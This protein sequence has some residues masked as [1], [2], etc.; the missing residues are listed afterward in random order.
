V[1]N[2][3]GPAEGSGA[4]MTQ[5]IGRWASLNG[6]SEVSDLKYGMDFRKPEYRREVFLRFYEFHLRYRSHPGGVYFLLPFLAE[7]HRWNLEQRLWF[8]YING[9]TQNPITSYLIFREFGD[10]ARLDETALRRWFERNYDL[11]AF[12]TD[13]R[14][15]KKSFLECVA[16]YRQLLAG[17]TQAEFFAAVAPGATEHARFRALWNYANKNYVY[18]GRLSVF[19]YTEYLRISGLSIDCDSLFLDDISG[20]KSHRNG[21]CKVLGRDDLDWHASNPGFDGT[22]DATM[23][24]WLTSEGAQLLAEAKARVAGKDYERDAGYFTLESALCTYKSWHRPNRRYPNCYNDMLVE[25]IRLAEK[26]WGKLPLFW[27]ARR[28][29]LPAALRLED[30][31]ADCGLKPKKQNHYLT[32]GQPVMM[33]SDWPCFAN[34]FEREVKYAQR[35]GAK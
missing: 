2:G 34:A 23:L 25:R 11:L 27:E 29:Y 7:V 31:P 9:N 19:S 21:L 24:A 18:F 32:T 35:Y 3:D 16:N 8:A 22:Y 13:R 15:F 4:V 12:D 17:R 28:R 5:R 20:S 1:G 10:V 30:N 26:R 14:Y 6:A 33:A